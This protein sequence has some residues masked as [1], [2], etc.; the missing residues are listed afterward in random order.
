MRSEYWDPFPDE[1]TH[2]LEV[3]L[4]G[5]TD[6]AKAAERDGVYGTV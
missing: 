3:E 4:V 1:Q 5:A 6:A 2:H